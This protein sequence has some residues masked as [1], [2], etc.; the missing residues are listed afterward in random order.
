MQ[1]VA[2]CA[3]SAVD[4]EK[5]KVNCDY[6]KQVLQAV[7]KELLKKGGKVPEK[8][9]RKIGLFSYDQFLVA[10][11][12]DLELAD[13]FWLNKDGGGGGQEYQWAAIW[14]KNKQFFF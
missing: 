7:A 2:I 12:T 3:E 13:L 9:S 14:E 1:A 8:L 6:R 11:V 5:M 10:F 4:L